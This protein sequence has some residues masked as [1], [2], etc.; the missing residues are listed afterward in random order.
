MFDEY[1]CFEEYE[2]PI[3]PSPQRSNFKEEKFSNE[4][5]RCISSVPSY[6]CAICCRI[7]Y[8]HEINLLNDSIEFQLSSFLI[9]NRSRWPVIYYF[10]RNGDPISSTRYKKDK[11]YIV[12]PPHNIK[13]KVNI[14]QQLVS[15]CPH[16]ADLVLYNYLYMR[17]DNISHRYHNHD[18]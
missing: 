7:L 11:K 16:L 14:I 3:C 5:K 13:D 1:D 6:C 4:K 8:S 9:R 2:N 10:E 17:I 18:R 15:I 12:C